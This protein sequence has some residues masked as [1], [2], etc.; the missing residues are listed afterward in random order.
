[1]L[2]DVDCALYRPERTVEYDEKSVP[3]R[4]DLAALMGREEGPNDRL[5]FIPK[6][7]RLGLVGL[8][9]GRGLRVA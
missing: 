5:L 8:G 4:L 1:M 2:L 3:G 6:S 9:R 7:Q